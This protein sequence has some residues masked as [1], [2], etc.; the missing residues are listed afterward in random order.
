MLFIG[1]DYVT[2][3][4]SLQLLVVSGKD[5]CARLESMPQQSHGEYHLLSSGRNHIQVNIIDSGPIIFRLSTDEE[6]AYCTV[7]REPGKCLVCTK[8]M[9]FFAN[10][11]DNISING[12]RFMVPPQDVYVIYRT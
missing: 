4:K 8:D 11:G 1:P 2:K 7:N 10:I 9:A 5:T 3:E 6:V 12:T